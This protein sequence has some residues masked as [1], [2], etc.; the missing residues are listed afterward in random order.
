MLLNLTV[1][2]A[3][4]V[5]INII[6][7]PASIPVNGT[8]VIQVDV[9]NNDFDL[10]AP[11]NKLRPLI[12]GNTLIEIVSIDN[13]DFTV[14]ALGTGA[15]NSIRMLYSKTLDPLSCATVNITIR[16]VQQ[17]PN[18][19]ITGTLGFQGPQTTNNNPANDNSTTGITVTAGAAAT[20]VATGTNPTS[21]GTSTGSVSL[22]G[23]GGNYPANAPVSVTYTS[24]SGPVVYSGT[25]DGTGKITIPNLPAG[26]YGPFTV[27]VDGGTPS[28]PGGSVTL[29]D[30]IPAATPVATGTNPSTIGGSNGSVSLSPASGSYP[31]NTPV[32]VTY[33]SPSGTPVVFSGTTDGT[34]KITIPNLPAGTYGPF[35]VAV[36]GGT[37]SAPGSPVTLVDP[38]PATPVAS[39]NNQP[40]SPGTST[41][42]VS[43]TGTGGNYPANAPVSVTYTSPSGPVVYSGT[44][45]GTG[46]IIIP[47]LPAGTY[48]P[49]SVAVNGGTPS[50]PGGNVTL[51]DPTPTAT[52]VATGTNPSTIGGS[53]GSV[54]LSPATGSYPAN[55]PVSVTYTSPSGPVVYSG[56]TDGTGKIIIPNLP[57][58][59]YGPFTVAVNGGTPSSPGGSATLVDPAPA[60]PVATGTNP[61]SPR[62][63]TGSVS[64]TGTAGNNYP[65]NAPISVTYTSPSGSVVYTGT[66]DGT[67]KITIPNLPAGTYGPF[68]VA[69]NGGTPSSPG[70]SATLV[71]PT[72]TSPADLSPIVYAR[73]STTRGTTAVTMVV[74]VI[75]LNN[76][77]TSGLITVRISKD[78]IINWSLNASLTTV[79]GRPVQNSAWTF[80]ASSNPDYYLLTTNSVI[81][82]S[83]QLSFGLSGTITPGST[84]GS[85]TQSASIAGGSGGETRFTNNADADRIDY[86]IR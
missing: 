48:G 29:S 53:N 7:R 19:T 58:G 24:P 6:S 63:S 68:T 75:E 15:N 10:V 49:F 69:V 27:A 59:S 9:C 11:A 25:T 43:L 30:P 51:A 72:P 12:S 14:Q 40:T 38:A 55:T 64:L 4:D 66:T 39:V 42:S 57:A 20:P 71:D 28:S 54:S 44:T 2:K 22:T 46:K 79:D 84:S 26:T 65:A 62:T 70:G 13:A 17:G 8:G 61:T 23:T 76:A 34:G 31:A 77:P 21:P 74:D 83:G 35:T 45:D 85:I 60:T 36:N 41:G 32:S 18:T 50:T 52:P 5:S 82:A 3:Q 1:A 86:F 16:G 81:A 67:G 37:P 80:D 33:T 78:D 47:N 73:P 56:T